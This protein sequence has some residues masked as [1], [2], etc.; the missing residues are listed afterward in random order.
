VRGRAERLVVQ[1]PELFEKIRTLKVPAA[2]VHDPALE[3]RLQNRFLFSFH[4]SML[5][6]TFGGPS[7]IL[8][9]RQDSITGYSDAVTM[10][11]CYPRGTLGLLDCA[12]HS[13][14][15]ERPEL[16]TAHIRDWL[17]RLEQT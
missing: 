13:L 5:A 15:W 4:D 2:N 6:T 7:L 10:L 1:T 3:A 12:G 17:V 16:F 9:G 11:E 8:S 14:S